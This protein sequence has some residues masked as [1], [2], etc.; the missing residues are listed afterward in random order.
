MPAAVGI[1]SKW[2]AKR[3]SGT[4]AVCCKKATEIWAAAIL[5]AKD[6]AQAEASLAKE[7]REENAA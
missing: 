6:I 3:D 2:S 7:I 1:I 4:M 5:K